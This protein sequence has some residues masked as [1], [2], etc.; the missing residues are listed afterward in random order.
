MLAY[1]AYYIWQGNNLENE[2]FILTLAVWCFWRHKTWGLFTLRV[3]P[4]ARN[5]GE[6]GHP[7]RP[8]FLP[9]WSWRFSSTKRNNV[10]VW[11]KKQPTLEIYCLPHT[12]T[13]SVKVDQ[14]G[15]PWKSTRVPK[16]DS[17]GF[18]LSWESKGHNTHPYCKTSLEIRGLYNGAFN[19]PLIR[20]AYSLGGVALGE[21]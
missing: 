6:L 16:L 4:R 3:E 19:N 5:C 11:E 2:H 8:P 15:P 17:A 20:P 21:V 7:K 10:N 13:I 1:Y 14:N 12:T 18:F 9:F